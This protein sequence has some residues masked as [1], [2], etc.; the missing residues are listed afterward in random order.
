[1]TEAPTAITGHGTGASGQNHMVR[2]AR[3]GA[4]N[5]AG[6][7]VSGLSAFALATVVTNGHT[8]A[9]AG[10]FFTTT[11][12]FLLATNLGQLGTNTGLV[13][14]LSRAR[15]A[16]TMRNAHRYMRLGMQ[17]VLLVGVLIAVA[18]WVWAE[19]LGALMSKGETDQTVTT[20]IRW[21]APFVPLAAVL[22]VSISGTR[23]LGTM[24]ANAIIDQLARP[25]LQLGLVAVASWWVSARQM[26]TLW[27]L[28]YLPLAA[29][30]WWSWRRMARRATRD[31]TPD[32]DYHPRRVFWAFTLPRGLAGVAQVAMQRLD[33]ILVGSMAGI[34]PAA[35]YAAT[36]RFLSLGLLA[37]GAISQAV[38][39]LLGEAL[40]RNDRRSA[41]ELYQTATAW[42]V[43]GAWPVYL[44]LMIFAP[45]ILRIFGKGY[46]GGSSV[47]ILLGASM[48][49]GT[50]CGMVSMVL[51][52]AGKTSWNLANVLLAFGVNIGLDLWLIPSHG[53]MGAAIGWSAAIL[54]ANVVPLIQVSSAFGLHPFGRGTL[55]AM[56]LA[57]ACMGAVP[58]GVRI[59]LGQSPRSLF[60]GLVLGGLLYAALLWR[61]RR[62]TA[63][64]DLLKAGRRRSRPAA[65][66]E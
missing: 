63:L 51:T 65:D 10:V 12:L 5:L 31:T 26:S 48:V 36:T 28:P 44:I 42:L 22:N 7:L 2:A 66:A 30:A 24:R 23:G 37:N 38:Q 33:V 16:G 43:I 62:R 19:P 64:L 41:R 39:P 15:G 47:L 35:V 40:G 3:G 8:K 18:M 34:G 59:V 17:P 21:L 29:I 54:A 1:M 13:Y 14:F 57:L 61:T 49:L 53:I 45:T 56:T 50:G 60:V 52:M 9:E 27:A 32:P 4:L 25:L 20:A 58:F 46:Q 6:A 11:S 55:L